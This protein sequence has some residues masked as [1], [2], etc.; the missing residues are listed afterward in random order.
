MMHFGKKK[1]K[2]KIM[3]SIE[4]LSNPLKNTSLDKRINGDK[5]K[6]SGK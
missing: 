1:I 4:N 5:K 2:K 6:T 3:C